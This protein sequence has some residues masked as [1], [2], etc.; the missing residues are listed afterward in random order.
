MILGLLNLKVLISKYIPKEI[1]DQTKDQTYEILLGMLE[2]NYGQLPKDIIVDQLFSFLS[3]EEHMWT[4]HRW[5]KQSKIYIRG[6]P[7]YDL[8]PK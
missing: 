3:S 4:A 5:I 7:V 1:V 8:Q 6:K 2:R